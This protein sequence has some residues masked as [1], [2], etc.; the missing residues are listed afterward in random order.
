MTDPRLGRIA[1]GV[2]I[3]SAAAIVVAGCATS[4]S[5]PEAEVRIGSRALVPPSDS[6]FVPLTCGTNLSWDPVGDPSG[7]ANGRDVVGDAAFPAVLRADLG[8]RILFRMRMDSTP[9]LAPEN[10]ASFGWGY[11]F[12]SDSTVDSYE[13]Y[14]VA[15][16][17]GNDE[18]QW[19]DNVQGTLDAPADPPETLL[20]QYMPAT[21]YW[22]VTDADSA[23]GSTPDYFLTIAVAQSDLETFGISFSCEAQIWA[24]SSNNGQTIDNDLACHDGNAGAATLSA[25]WLGPVPDPLGQNDIDGDGL[26]SAIEEASLLD[27]CDPDSDDDGLRDGVDGTGDTDG[28]SLPD[29]LDPDSDGDG[30]ND[31]TEAGV[32]TAS[33]LPG[34]DVGAPGFRPDADPSTVTD[35]DDADSDDDGLDDGEEDV[36]ATGGVDVGETDPADFDTD[37]G[38]VGDGVEADR[39][40][41]PLRPGDDFHVAGSGSCSVHPGAAPSLLAMLLLLLPLLPLR[42]RAQ[43]RS[44]DIEIQQFRPAGGFHDVLALPSARVAAHRSFTVSLF[45]NHADRPFRLIDPSDGS[46]EGSLVA[47][48]SQMDVAASVG[49]IDRVEIAAAL[50][51]TVAR[52][53]GGTLPAAPGLGREVGSAGLSDARLSAKAHLLRAGRMDLGIAS[54]LTV[55]TGK[56]DDFLGQGGVTWSPRVLADVDVGRGARLAANLGLTLRDEQQFLNLRVGN[57]VAFGAGAEVPFRLGSQELAFV[58]TLTG[59][60]G[61]RESGVEGLPLELIAGASWMTR[62]GFVLTLAGGRGLTDGYGAPV[63]RV[64]GG[65]AYAPARRRAR[66]M[67]SEPP[68]AITTEGGRLVLREKIVFPTNEDTISPESFPILDQLAEFLGGRNAPKRLRIEGHTDDTGTPERNEELSRNRA[69]RVREYLVSKGIDAG[70][71]ESEGFGNTKPLDSNETEAGRA[72]NRRVDFVILE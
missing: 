33:A 66:E 72:N 12:D 7:G 26:S 64:V 29:A 6:A 49:L 54:P 35:P 71:L 57:A 20:R 51:L 25:A 56:A 8:D 13:K 17:V 38:G 27:P 61:L 50:P 44:R 52:S 43:E 37:D 55:P 22:A 68:P 1:R 4:A 34:T 11:L 32:T 47:R 3:V 60:K 48:Q 23:F 53:A 46:T 15:N 16:G 5:A 70:R 41:D 62:A 21:D 40:T 65:L 9:L 31:G 2:L 39:G 30:V 69:M 63:Y 42:A 18:M 36:N 67:S 14:F 19:W 24:G 28:D 10:L 59:E 58:T 45:A